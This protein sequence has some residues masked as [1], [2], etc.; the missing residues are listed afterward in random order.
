MSKKEE[1]LEKAFPDGFSLQKDEHTPGDTTRV[2]GRDRKAVFCVRNLDGII[3][4]KALDFS[5]AFR[6][7][8]VRS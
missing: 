2:V 4:R 1:A 5:S 6:Y 7:N 8:L 3:K